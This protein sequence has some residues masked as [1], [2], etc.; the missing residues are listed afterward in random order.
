MMRNFQQFAAVAAALAILLVGPAAIAQEDDGSE[1]GERLAKLRSDVDRLSDEVEDKKDEIDSQMRSTR[2]QKVDLEARAEREER[3]NRQLNESLA[4]AEERVA[5]QTE[6]KEELI[7]AVEAAIEQVREPVEAGLP[8]KRD[9]RLGELDDLREQLDDGVLSPQKAT[10]RLWQFVED[11]L[12]L[13]RESGLHRQSVEVDGEEVLAD[14]VRIGMVAL[15]YQ[16]NNGDVGAARHRDG[17]WRWERF[18]G[19]GE[20]ERIAKLFESFEKNV[21]VGFFT[22]PNALPLGGR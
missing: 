13:A 4:E 3:R 1:L 6:G 14:V 12:R 9:E 7:P 5:K 8:F 20:R 15:Y 21:R 16:T 10:A 17:Q 22:L 11:E 18:E 19:E 2:N